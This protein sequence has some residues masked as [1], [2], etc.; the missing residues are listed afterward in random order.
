[1]KNNQLQLL[2]HG[3]NIAHTTPEFQYEGVQLDH[4]VLTENPNYQFVY[5]K[6]CP[7]TKPGTFPIRFMKEEK[8]VAS[9]TY[10]LKEREE[11]SAG[12]NGFSSADVMYLFMPDRFANGDLSND[13]TDDTAEKADRK[14]QG[15][16][17]GGDIQGIINHLDYLNELGITAIWSTPVL[18]DNCPTYSYHG[19]AISDYYKIDPRYGTN[20]KYREMVE[21][22][23]EKGI[24]VVMDM[25]S[26]HCGSAH[27]WMDDLPAEDWIHQHEK[28]TRT[29][30]EKKTANDPHASQVDKKLNFDG[31]FDIT[32]PD[33]N[34]QNP[35]LLQYLIQNA[36]W[37]VEYSGLDG[38]RM[39]TYPYNDYDAM[40]KWAKGIMDEYPNFNIVG[41]CWQNEAHEIAFWQR[42]S[43]NPLG[44]NSYLKTVMDFPLN[45]ALSKCF[46]E[47]EGWS[48]GLRRIYNSIAND[49]LYPDLN[50]ILV[51]AENHDTQRYN[52][53]L[54]EDIDKYKLAITFL[55]TTRGIPQL[56]YG[57]EIMMT[58]D[59]ETGDGDIRRDF[60]GGWPGD[61]INCFTDE[62]RNAVQNE[63]FN[64]TRKVLNYRK[65]NPVIHTGKLM[66]FIPQDGCYVYFR[67][68][69]EK[70]IMVVLNNNEKKE[71]E[72][73]G[74][75]FKEVLS[76]FTSGYEIVHDLKFDDLHR[77]KVPAKTGYIIEL[78]K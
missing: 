11:G 18:E 46:N 10:E 16:R 59:K 2:V 72:L 38:I 14:Q 71:I 41:E 45:G 50:N 37:W 20:E 25:I 73:E 55:A 64:H 29:N 21:K 61:E 77:I 12:R 70:T 39:D 6:I 66:H 53:V 62:G 22:C 24:K 35:L 58:G 19:Y 69:D 7:D 26:N 78:S 52:K 47:E 54:G 57:S 51:F 15:G 30:H 68:S 75:R 65:N 33:L 31:W 13:S 40:S 44:Y 27:W 48:T 23:H 8:T 34:Q 67:Y 28:F 60:P 63:A 42:N 3:E 4:I 74:N 56:Y 9:Y 76:D 49:Y 32:M 17:H 1:M 5:L 36:I 43:I